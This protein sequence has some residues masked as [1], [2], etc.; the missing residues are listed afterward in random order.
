L[1]IERQPSRTDLDVSGDGQ[2]VGRVGSAAEGVNTL[3]RVL[4]SFIYQQLQIDQVNRQSA[5]IPNN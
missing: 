3:S 2:T 4:G 1:A 5:P